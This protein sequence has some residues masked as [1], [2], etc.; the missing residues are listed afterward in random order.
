MYH[1][2]DEYNRRYLV[3]GFKDP[4]VCLTWS[5]WKQVFSELNLQPKII[6]MY[7][8]FV[9]IAASMQ[10]R[11]NPGDI[12]RF[13][14]LAHQ[15][16]KAIMKNLKDISAIVRYNDLMYETEMITEYLTDKLEYLISDFSFIDTKL[17][18]RNG[19]K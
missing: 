13:K 19:K 12:D 17:A 15:Y 10:A 9:D 16:Y 8:N 5:A 2:I 1:L 14:A 7:R 6:L 18:N 3:W 4:R 11:N